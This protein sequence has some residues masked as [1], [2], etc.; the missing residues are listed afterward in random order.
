MLRI[1]PQAGDAPIKQL[2]SSQ[3]QAD[4]DLKDAMAASVSVS[5]Q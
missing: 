3:E 4:E 1:A 2:S 5:H